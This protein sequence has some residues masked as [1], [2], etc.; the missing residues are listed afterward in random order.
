MTR[1]EIALGVG[2]PVGE[3]APYFEGLAIGEARATHCAS[4]DR[5]WFAPRLACACGSGALSWTK[6]SGAGIVVAATRTEIRLPGEEAAMPGTFAWIAMEGAS[7]RILG[8]IEGDGTV[9]PG[10]RVELVPDSRPRAGV[11]WRAVFRVMSR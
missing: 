4:C 11:C 10:D 8:T 5:T 3:L 9:V 6:L 7:N 1:L 2:R